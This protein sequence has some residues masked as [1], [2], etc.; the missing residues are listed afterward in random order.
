MEPSLN[1][2]DYWIPECEEI[3]ELQEYKD[4]RED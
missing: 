1:E 3:D 4:S 2:D